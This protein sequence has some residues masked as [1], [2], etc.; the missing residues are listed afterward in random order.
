MCKCQKKW[1]TLY[2]ALNCRLVVSHLQESPK[3]LYPRLL[4]IYERVLNCLV[5]C[6]QL[7]RIYPSFCVNVHPPS[8]LCNA[9]SRGCLSRPVAF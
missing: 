7:Y 1:K 3:L 5:V 8:L 4:Y 9:Q 2:C 6:G